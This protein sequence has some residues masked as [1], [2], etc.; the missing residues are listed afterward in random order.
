MKALSELLESEKQYPKDVYGLS[1]LAIDE[2]SPEQLGFYLQARAAMSDI[3]RLVREHGELVAWVRDEL[4]GRE[5]HPHCCE[6][7][8]FICDCGLDYIRKLVGGEG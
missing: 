8:G 1:G 3:E 7:K 2:M 6:P 5:H 4:K